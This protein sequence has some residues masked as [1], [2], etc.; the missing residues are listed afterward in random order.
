MLTQAPQQAS[1]DHQ[2]ANILH[3]KAYTID[4]KL[5]IHEI[6]QPTMLANSLVLQTDQQSS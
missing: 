3:W 4:I 5:S 6:V 1:Q 2:S